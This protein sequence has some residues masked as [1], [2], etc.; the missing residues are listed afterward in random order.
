M[1][2]EN[3][4]KLRHAQGLTQ[5]EFAE[6]IGVSRNSLSRY[7][8]GSSPISTDII[9]RICQAFQVSYR[10]IVGEEKM[11][12][13]L[14][15]YQLSS[16]IDLFKERAASILARLY[17]FQDK[18]AIAFDDEKNP[19]VLLGDDLSMIIQDKIY[20]IQS[21]EELERYQGYL[22]GIERMLDLAEQQVVA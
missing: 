7:E 13:P 1:I 11:I 12:N 15:E 6:R 21:V 20:S 3:I 14:E 17:H 22:D 2:G 10:E 4:R 8:N 16:K 18:H 5:P 19:W 9:D